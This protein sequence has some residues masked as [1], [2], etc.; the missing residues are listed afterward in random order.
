MEK[1]VRAEKKKKRQ[2]IK[3]S[4]PFMHSR[5]R[6]GVQNLPGTSLHKIVTLSYD[7]IDPIA[8]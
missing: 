2:P 6:N 3:M 8:R 7:K 1:L 4:S 5:G